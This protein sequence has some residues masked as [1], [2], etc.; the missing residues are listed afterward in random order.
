MMIDPD[1]VRGLL[2]ATDDGYPAAL[3]SAAPVIA[4][5]YLDA[6]AEVARLRTELVHCDQQI[7]ATRALISVYESALEAALGGAS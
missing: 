6:D 1:W 5:A 3:R 7:T 2:D 4:Q